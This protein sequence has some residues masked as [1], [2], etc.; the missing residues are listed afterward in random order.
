VKTYRPYLFIL[1]L[2]GSVLSCTEKKSHN[3]SGE[4]IRVVAH[5][6]MDDVQ[7]E[8]EDF[9][10]SIK[11]KKSHPF[12]AW[13]DSVLSFYEERDFHPLWDQGDTLSGVYKDLIAFLTES[14]N[15]EGLNPEWYTV[16]E[17][18]KSYDKLLTYKR[19]RY[20]KRAKLECLISLNMM[21]IHADH[22]EGRTNPKDVFGGSYNLPVTKNEEIHLTEILNTTLYQEVFD[23]SSIRN[24]E[25]DSYRELLGK[26]IELKENGSIWEVLDFDTIKKIEVGM[27]TELLPKV[28][29]KLWQM[30]IISNEELSLADSFE[31]N[32][33]FEP[34]IKRAQTSFGL[35]DDGI[36][37]RNTIKILNTSIDS[38]IDEIRANMERIRWFTPDTS[39]KHILVN[40]P[41]Y[42]LKINYIDSV[43]GMD[44]CVGKAKSHT[45]D[46]QLKKF[47][48]TGKWWDRPQNHQT[49]QIYSKV[50]YM[51]LNP[52]WTVPQSI[53]MREMY[54]LMRRDSTYLSSHGYRVFDGDKELYPDTIN[55]RKYE[56]N[57]IPF[58]FV[59]KEGEANALG[60][61]KFI[62]SN[63]FSIYL[64]DT[65]QKSK[66]KWTERA[67][68]HGCVRI[69]D[70][71]TMAE[72]LLKGNEKFS[73]D[74]FRI[75]LGMEP[76]E[77]ERLKDYDPLDTLAEIRPIDTTELVYLHEKVPIYFLYRTIYFDEEQNPIFR[78]DVYNKNSILIE[79][80]NN[81]S[82]REEEL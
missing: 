53:V 16:N 4:K 37:G 54:H 13:A 11:K 48:V 56:A 24:L 55:W 57:N 64:H 65:P 78:N 8:I 39:E 23:S 74:D 9:L 29:R 47:E 33:E 15:K 68:S 52:T 27:P 7:D 2:L 38:R 70:P 45:F 34:I 14:A 10:K 26:W 82:I 51:V 72:F 21:R 6:D 81:A 17:L 20:S 58:K 35:M 18:E 31:Y 3:D 42:S 66:F 61:V 30:G 41:D 60:K 22:I 76:L 25:Y 28:A 43:K 12:N 62:F 19:P 63:R 80:M 71:I 73:Y 67:V 40:I 75:K 79:S 50:R 32:E 59:Q 46:E 1:I 44:V 49:P 77:E 5:Y 36:L 69:S